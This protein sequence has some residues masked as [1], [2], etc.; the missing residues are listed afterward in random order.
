MR[1]HGRPWHLSIWH[2]RTLR[3]WLDSPAALQLAVETSDAYG[4]HFASRAEVDA[5]IERLEE[6]PFI[7]SVHVDGPASFALAYA[8]DADGTLTLRDTGGV[9]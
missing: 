3:P 6:D 4:K 7:V 2:S 1:K 9:S 8:R 5:E